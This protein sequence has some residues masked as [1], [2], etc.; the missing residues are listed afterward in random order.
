MMKAEY[1]SEIDFFRTLKQRCK[2]SNV[3]WWNWKRD[4]RNSKRNVQ[5][6]EADRLKDYLSENFPFTQ[7]AKIVLH[8]IWEGV[9]VI[10]PG[11]LFVLCFVSVKY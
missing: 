5:L 6:E 11:A 4:I 9:I 2:K 10:V 8:H 3:R 1:R 7:Q